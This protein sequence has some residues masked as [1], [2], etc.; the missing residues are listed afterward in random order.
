MS[1]HRSLKHCRNTISIHTIN[2]A[3][4]K[5]EKRRHNRLLRFIKMKEGRTRDRTLDSLLH[6]NPFPGFQLIKRIR[7]SKLTK[8][9]KMKVG[10]R[11]Y[12]GE[13]VPDGIYQSIKSL[14]SD[15]I[16]HNP[17]LSIPSFTE[18]YRHIL[19]ICKSGKRI[20]Q[21]SKEKSVKI[22]RSIRKNVVDEVNAQKQLQQLKQVSV[23]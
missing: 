13:S 16:P 9:N 8:V 22:L 6:K 2:L 23:L 7:S 11:V 14:K 1:C 19:N 3:K 20:P 15:P 4:Y 18:E 12:L 5:E 21:L 17:D 10:S